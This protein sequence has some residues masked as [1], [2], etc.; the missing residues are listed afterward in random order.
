MITHVYSNVIKMHSLKLEALQR[1]NTHETE[2]K[3]S[4]Q[5]KLWIQR[6]KIS[7]TLVYSIE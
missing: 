1:K 4:I 2:E 6:A 5:I 3:D 7:M